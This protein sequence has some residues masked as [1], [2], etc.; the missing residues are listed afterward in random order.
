MASDHRTVTRIATI[1]EYAARN[2]DGIRLADTA[3]ELD[4]PRSSAHG[5]LQGLVSVGYLVQRSDA[6]Y[7]LGGGLSAILNRDRKL[8]WADVA[9][10]VLEDLAGITG[11]TALLGQRF[12][13]SVV[14]LDQVQSQQRIRYA[15][16]LRVRR[17]L[18]PTSMGKVLLA[19]MTPASAA[20]AV[21]QSLGTGLDDPATKAALAELDDVRT[22]GVAFN[23]D[24]TV[25][26]VSAVAS[27]VKSPSGGIAAAIGVV[28]PS[29]RVRPRLDELA[30]L[31]RQTVRV[32]E[33]NLAQHG[34]AEGLPRD[35]LASAETVG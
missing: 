8:S 19:E 29:E 30:D 20:A 11:E 9:H 34:F 27:G 1:L 31:V 5:L 33:E 15:A 12:G 10:D 6:S 22:S 21:S 13:G 25:D 26:G 28:G 23:L 7:V 16:D 24:E 17:P 18:Y 3:A 32:V 4:S 2:P 14:Y 35:G